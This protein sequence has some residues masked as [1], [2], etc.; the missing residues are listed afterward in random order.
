MESLKW[1]RRDGRTRSCPFL[2]GDPS[3]GSDF[4]VL[5]GTALSANSQ[6]RRGEQVGVARAGQVLA[7]GPKF[8]PRAKVYYAS[9]RMEENGGPWSVPQ[10][11]RKQ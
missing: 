3:M 2:S 8:F 6:P 5:S 4:G 7:G 11:P 9:G 1:H 10:G